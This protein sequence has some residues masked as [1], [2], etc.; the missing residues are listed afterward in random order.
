VPRRFPP[1]VD[2]TA[3]SNPKTGKRGPTCSFPKTDWRRAVNTNRWL[4]LACG[5]P[6][7]D[8]ASEKY[9]GK[10]DFSSKRHRKREKARR[11]GGED[12]IR[13]RG[14]VSPDD[15]ALLADKVRI[16]P[17]C[18]KQ[19]VQPGESVGLHGAGSSVRNQR[20]VLFLSMY[21]SPLWVGYSAG[22]DKRTDWMKQRF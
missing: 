14:C 15:R 9:K 2:G 5:T 16:S 8:P 17:I 22:T 12:W 1:V 11:D 10:I 19:R 18:G 3:S 7:A 21:A 20:L 6:L 4:S 13:T